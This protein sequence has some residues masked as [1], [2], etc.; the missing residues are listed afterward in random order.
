MNIVS[1]CGVD[2]DD[3]ISYQTESRAGVGKQDVYDRTKKGLVEIKVGRGS[4]VHYHPFGRMAVETRLG[5]AIA[6]ALPVVAR[7]RGGWRWRTWKG[8]KVLL[9]DAED[10]VGIALA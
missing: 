3:K 10:I 1:E 7:R 5:S 9:S 2:R 8:G 6:P 4:G